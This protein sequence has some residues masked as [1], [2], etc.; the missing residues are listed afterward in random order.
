GGGDTDIITDDQGNAYFADLEGLAH[1]GVAVS[2]D[3]GLNWRENFVAAM[4]PVDDRQCLAVDTGPTGGV[5][6]NTVF[7][8]YRPIP[9]HSP[10]LS[11]PGSTGPTDTVGGFVYTNAATTTFV[12]AGSPCGRLIFDPVLRN[13]YL[14]CVQGNHIHVSKAHVNPG[15]RDLLA[16]SSTNTPASPG[17]TIGNL[18]ASLTTDRD[19]N[20]YVAWVDTTNHNVYLTVSTIA[21]PSWPSPHTV[22]RDP[23]N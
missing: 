14:P 7:L 18:F 19:R 23:A 4:A 12:G 11:S 15:Q 3:Q 9:G 8:S 6:D 10:V 1:I 17:S 2:N 16:F 21:G 22:N 20:V 5:S 13:L